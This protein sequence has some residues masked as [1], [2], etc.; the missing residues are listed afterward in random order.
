MVN[1]FCKNDDTN[2]LFTKKRENTCI[3]AFFEV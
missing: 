3:L 1:D 2:G